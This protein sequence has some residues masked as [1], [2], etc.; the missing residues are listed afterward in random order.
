MQ[1][2]PAQPEFN[3]RD[4]AFLEARPG[5]KNSPNLEAAVRMLAERGVK[6]PSEHFYG[7]LEQIF[8]IQAP[9]ASPEQRREQ[10]PPAGAYAQDQR[11]A[12]ERVI[13]DARQGH[14]DDAQ[15]IA[16]SRSGDPSAMYVSAPPH[17]ETPSYS[18]GERPLS[19]TSVRLSPNERSIARLSGISEADY[20]RNKL[21]MMR[22]KESGLI[23]DE[24]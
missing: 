23:T 10:P 7:A 18:T 21:K 20:A 24:G 17:R 15:I 5:L 6:W 14:S 8:P 12:D 22:Y 16:E 9:A 2:A 19:Q 3:T 4:I 11:S 1:Q 13:A